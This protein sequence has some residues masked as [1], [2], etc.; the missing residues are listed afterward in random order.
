VPEQDLYATEAHHAQEV[1]DVVLP[2]N[3]QP[4]EVMKPGE[5]SFYSPTS[6]VAAQRTTVLRRHTAIISML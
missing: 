1:I 5:G 2:A 4:T 6:A 3:H